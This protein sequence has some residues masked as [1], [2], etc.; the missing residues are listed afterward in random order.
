[1]ELSIREAKSR[2]T[3]VAAAAARGERV[4]ITKYGHPFIEL[5]PAQG[6]GGIDEGKAAKIRRELGIDGL[7]VRISPEFDDPAFSREV[8]GLTE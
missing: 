3:E 6:V 5:I 8:L 7:T 4:I 2:F 1:M